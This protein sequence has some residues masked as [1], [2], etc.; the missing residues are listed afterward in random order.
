MP[1]NFQLLSI[2]TTLAV[3]G[4]TGSP[5]VAEFSCRWH[6]PAPRAKDAMIA[7]ARVVDGRL[8]ALHLVSKTGVIPDG[9]PGVCIYDL[10]DLRFEHGNADDGGLRLRFLNE[11]GEGISYLDYRVAD[12]RLTIE[13]IEQSGC[14]AGRILLPIEM[15][16]SSERCRIGRAA[17]R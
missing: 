17:V 10:H 13:N 8:V 11:R 3:A 7:N 2:A 16:L 12:D 5:K 15:T 4:C 14:F 6:E 9:A 1:R